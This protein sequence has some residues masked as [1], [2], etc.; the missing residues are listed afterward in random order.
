MSGMVLKGINSYKDYFYGGKE[1]MDKKIQEQ[2]NRVHIKVPM[3]LKKPE[4]INTTIFLRIMEYLVKQDSVEFSIIESI[5]P[6]KNISKYQYRTNFTQM[7]NFGKK[8]NA[9]VFERNGD[10]IKIWEPVKNFV[11]EKYNSFVK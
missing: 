1:N 9:K 7:S 4:Q 6:T 8:N 3:W 10:V 5:F 2:I 11:L